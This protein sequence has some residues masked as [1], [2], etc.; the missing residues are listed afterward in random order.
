MQRI[1]H[2][3]C[4]WFV[5]L[6]PFQM[7]LMAFESHTNACNVAAGRNG[8]A[9]ASSG[10]AGGGGSDGRGSGTSSGCS[11]STSTSATGACQS[12][13]REALKVWRFCTVKLRK[14]RGLLPYTKALCIFSFAYAVLQVDSC[15]KFNA[16]IACC[17]WVGGC[18][19]GS[20]LRR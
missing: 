6:R 17:R 4:I 20:G 10:A 3:E 2:S 13:W 15:N 14:I 7:L 1:C 8:A 11:S 9:S 5:N 16:S 12:A 19:W 18:G